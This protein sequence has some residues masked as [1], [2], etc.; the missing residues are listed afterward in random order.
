MKI[1]INILLLV[2]FMALAVGGYRYYRESHLPE[3][4]AAQAEREEQKQ[5]DQ[6]ERMRRKEEGGQPE[7]DSVFTGFW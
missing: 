1:V 3:V 4:E 6:E 5:R 2:F 7:R